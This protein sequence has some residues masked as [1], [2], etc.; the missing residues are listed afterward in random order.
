MCQ[1]AAQVFLVPTK[2]RFSGVSDRS[3][4]CA[5]V[6]KRVLPRSFVG[7]RNV[8]VQLS[9]DHELSSGRTARRDRGYVVL[10][11]YGKTSRHNEI[12]CIA[13]PYG[14]F[15][16]ISRRGPSFRPLVR[17]HWGAISA[18]GPQVDWQWATLTQVPWSSND[19]A[20]NC[21]FP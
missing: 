7:C 17:A 19:R 20:R 2:K 21:E 1:R 6:R 3:G 9:E 8:A 10:E 11:S 15:A 18:V 12:P 4:H 5:W 13:H 16:Q 14:R